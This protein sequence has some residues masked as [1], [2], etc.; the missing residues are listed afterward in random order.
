MT[1]ARLTTDDNLQR[2]AQA[3]AEP[4]RLRVLRYVQAADDA[5]TVGEVA[6]RFGLH[7]NAVRQ[8]LAHLRDAGLLTEQAARRG[9]AGR[10]RLT[11]RPNPEAPDVVG[12]WNPYETLATLLVDIAAGAPA[13]EVGAAYGRRLGATAPE[14]GAVELLAGVARRH[15]FRPTIEPGDGGVDLVLGRCPFAAS[16]TGDRLVCELHRGIADGVAA[17]RDD[18]VVTSLDLAAPHEGGCRF[19]VRLMHQGETR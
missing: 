11:Y 4:T 18:A 8:H 7:P 2:V 13:H 5:V 10:P 9:G 16:V 19:H 17:S 12:G 15:G 1:R 14:A 3:V 6:E